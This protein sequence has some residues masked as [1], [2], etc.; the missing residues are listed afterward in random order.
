MRF[1][2][3]FLPEA[4]LEFDDAADWYEEQLE[5]L[6]AEFVITVDAALSQISERPFS[7][8]AIENFPVRRI[9]LNRFPYSVIYSVEGQTVLVYAIFHNSRNPLIWRG[10]IG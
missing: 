3:E 5:G 7:Y 6:R 8:P 9:L 2:I 1:N 10:R 4:R